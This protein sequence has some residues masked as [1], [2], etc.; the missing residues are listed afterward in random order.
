MKPCFA[1][2][3]SG[4]LLAPVFIP[5]LIDFLSMPKATGLTSR[6]WDCYNCVLTLI[7]SFDR[8]ILSFIC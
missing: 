8:M 4:E 3:A 7:F 1:S 2:Q 6:G 5:T